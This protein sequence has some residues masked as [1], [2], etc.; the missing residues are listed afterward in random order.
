VP[1]ALDDLSAVHHEDQVG[2]YGLDNSVRH[3]DCG[4]AFRK[5]LQRHKNAC[6]RLS[7]KSAGRLVE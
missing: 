2:M 6:F 7:I 1:S 3:A 5:I 4:P